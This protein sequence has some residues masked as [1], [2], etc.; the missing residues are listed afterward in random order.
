MTLSGSHMI[1]PKSELPLPEGTTIPA[2]FNLKKRG[3]RM[4]ILEHDE[5][6]YK[7]L[8]LGLKDDE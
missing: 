5:D 4:R 2:D 1:I 7:V 8:K 6:H 3:Y